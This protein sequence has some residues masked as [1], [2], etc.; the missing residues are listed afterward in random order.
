MSLNS[1]DHYHHRYKHEDGDVTLL[2]SDG[3][4]FRVHSFLL[5]TNSSVFRD[6]LDLARPSDEA[7]LTED[8][9]TLSSLLDFV[10]PSDAP[11]LPK[12][13]TLKDVDVLVEVAD[14]YNMPRVI[15]SLR[16]IALGEE[17]YRTSPL[18]LYA[19]AC[20]WK[21]QDV[22]EVASTETLKFN[23]NEDEYIDELKQLDA[24]DICRLL[25]LH[26]QRKRK[27]VKCLTPLLYDRAYSGPNPV[28]HYANCFCMEKMVE[29]G[30]P[31]DDLEASKALT[32]DSAFAAHKILQDFISGALDRRPLGDHLI[33]NAFSHPIFDFVRNIECPFCKTKYF[34]LDSIAADIW[35]KVDKGAVR[36][37]RFIK[38]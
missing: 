15:A 20:K 30:D 6:M 31:E 19:L 17:K 9:K 24:V 10:Y 2:A 5:K 28:P 14:K 13:A 23:L 37:I 8:S 33:P 11:S 26:A 22:A 1:S 38:D 35:T 18:D 29:H 21:W 16:S 7:I 12:P 4:K 27:I 3:L 25:K 34:S 32:I 36:S